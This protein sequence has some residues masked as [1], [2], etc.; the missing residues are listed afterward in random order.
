[1]AGPEL[2]GEELSQLRSVTFVAC[3]ASRGA[4]RKVAFESNAQ[5]FQLSLPPGFAL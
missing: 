2:S 3:Y 1:L 4:I 5:L